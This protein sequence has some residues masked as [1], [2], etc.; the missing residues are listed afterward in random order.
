MAT[1]TK[2]MR[3]PIYFIEFLPNLTVSNL[4][5]SK[6]LLRKLYWVFFKL[7][8]SE[9]FTGTRL[10]VTLNR[11]STWQCL[12]DALYSLVHVLY[13]V[14]VLHPVRSPQ[15]IFYTDWFLFYFSRGL[16]I[17]CSLGCIRLHGFSNRVFIWTVYKKAF[18]LDTGAKS[19]ENIVQNH[20]NITLLNVF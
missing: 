5:S 13:L 15:S 9:I 18:R 1:S 14:R 10:C 16:S 12:V 3:D 11:T 6:L 7:N 4:G 17:K 2:C 8:K 20:L 19:N